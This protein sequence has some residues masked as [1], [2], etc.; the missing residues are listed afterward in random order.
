MNYYRCALI[1]LLAFAP[2][3]AI[4]QQRTGTVFIVSTTPDKAIIAADSRGVTD[5]GASK[6]VNEDDQG[7]IMA[8]DNKAIFAMAGFQ[9]CFGPTKWNVLD[10][11]REVY[12]SIVRQNP[13]HP[14]VNMAD[15]FIKN[16]NRKI[17]ELLAAN[18]KFCVPN[19][20]PNSSIIMTGIFI[21]FDL[22]DRIEGRMATIKFPPSGKPDQFPVELTELPI[23]GSQVLAGE[24]AILDE[25]F[26]D[27]SPRAKQWHTVIDKYPRERRI[28]A[29][30]QLTRKFDTTGH[31]GG[32]IDMAVLT[33]S[34]IRW[35]SRK[36]KCQ[37]NQKY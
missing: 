4:S 18:W 2:Y 32:N 37:H 1:P 3:R 6:N 30:A 22:L 8:F 33:D 27:Q 34:G 13:K 28:Q 17:G 11:T 20:E 19:L 26:A 9:T 24:T 23:E 31:V 29:L 5:Y 36:S 14:G 16:W 10:T 7:K 35:V 12:G 21:D 25:F 15:L